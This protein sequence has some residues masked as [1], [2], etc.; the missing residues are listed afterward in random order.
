MAFVIGNILAPLLGGFL[1]DHFDFRTC[2]AFIAGIELTLFF[3]FLIFSICIIPKSVLL[4]KA[5]VDLLGASR[6]EDS[7]IVQEINASHEV[8]GANDGQTRPLNYS[9]LLDSK[10]ESLLDS[11][12]QGQ[13]K[14][15]A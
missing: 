8:F 1:N 12:D 4:N 14:Q 5:D 10:A 3:F 11:T 7:V 13:G 15:G 9:N 6:N 2:C